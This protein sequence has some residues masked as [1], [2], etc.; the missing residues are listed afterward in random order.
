MTASGRANLQDAV[1]LGFP[2]IC[3]FPLPSASKLK[4]VWKGSLP[5]KGVAPS[6]RSLRAR[7]ACLWAA[8]PKGACWVHMESRLPLVMR[9]RARA[10][11]SPQK[12]QTHT[13][14]LGLSRLLLVTLG[15]PEAGGGPQGEGTDSSETSCISS[16]CPCC[17]FSGSYCPRAPSF[18]TSC[19]CHKHG[20]PSGGQNGVEKEP[21]WMVASVRVRLRRRER[22][23][24]LAV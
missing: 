13:S 2:V 16:R 7:R 19:F 17:R 18:S 21:W 4:S 11:A 15:Q 14:C 24:T 10:P 22:E 12:L 3:I 23:E 5:V 1:A 9:H 20:S 6:R 8:A